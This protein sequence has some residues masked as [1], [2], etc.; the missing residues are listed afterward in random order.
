MHSLERM[1]LDFCL[2]Q[3]ADEVI[4]YTEED[5]RERIKQLTAGKGLDVAFDPVG[6]QYSESV[7][8]SMSWGGRFLVIGFTGGEIPKIP[9]NL[10]LLK[11]CSIV[12]VYW[13][14]FAQRFPEQDR[15]N[16]NRI[17]GWIT[18]GKLKPVIHRKYSLEDAKLAFNALLNRDVMGKIII[19]PNS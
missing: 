15:E 3:G 10:P 19:D 9:L 2:E 16:F 11:G 6:G 4:N 17:T 5:L 18:E 7:L 13:G 14:S 8:R 12:G 1:K